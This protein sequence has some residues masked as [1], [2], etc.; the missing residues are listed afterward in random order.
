MRTGTDGG[1]PPPRVSPFRFVENVSR[2]TDVQQ[3]EAFASKT[4][5]QLAGEIGIPGIVDVGEMLRIT[6]YARLGELGTPESLDAVRRIEATARQWPTAPMTISRARSPHPAWHM[7]TGPFRPLA[8][9]TGENGVH[10]AIILASYFGPWNA[11]LV[12][13]HVPADVESWTRPKLIP[14]PIFPGVSEPRLVL[15]AADRLVFTFTHVAPQHRSI[16]KAH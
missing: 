7:S 3:L 6:A 8:E 2:L 11:F 16:M 12:S 15:Q 10:Y 9:T 4:N 5:E 14:R 1:Q 13:D